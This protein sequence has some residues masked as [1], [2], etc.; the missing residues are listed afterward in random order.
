MTGVVKG[1][2]KVL[3]TMNIEKISKV[4]DKFEKQFE[5]LDVQTKYMEGAMDQT[6]AMTTPE[7]Q[8]KDLINQVADEHGLPGRCRP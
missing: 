8:V 6:T 1:M 4:M 2:D 7:D 5:D 3:A